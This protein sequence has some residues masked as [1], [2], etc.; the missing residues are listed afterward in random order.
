M[1]K[2][3]NKNAEMHKMSWPF[4]TPTQKFAIISV[5]LQANEEKQ[6][7]TFLGQKQA[8]SFADIM[9]RT[10]KYLAEQISY[11][12]R[13]IAEMEKQLAEYDN[14]ANKLKELY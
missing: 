2:V 12:K 5:F 8:E 1:K 7:Q 6:L 14:F 10:S 9:T 13:D 4:Y 3:F 11:K